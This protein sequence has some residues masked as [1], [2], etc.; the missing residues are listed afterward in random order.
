MLPV[1]AHHFPRGCRPPTRRQRFG[2]LDREIACPR[3]EEWR[4]VTE[5]LRDAAERLRRRDKENVLQSL[6]RA[7]DLW[8]QP[9]SAQLHVAETTLSATTG[10][11]AP[12]IRYGLPKTLAALDSDSIRGLLAAELQSNPGRTAIPPCLI[13]H[14]LSGNI[15][16]LGAVAIHLSLAIGSAAILKTAAGDPLSAALWARTIAEVDPELADC[17]AV[18]YWPGGDDLEYAVFEQVDVIVASGSDTAISAL[19]RRARRRFC[20][21]G[22]RVSFAAIGGE[23]LEDTATAATLA[24]KLAR[25]ISLWDQQ[26]CLSPQVCY[27]EDGSAVGPQTFAH[28]LAD[29]LAHDAAEFPP[30]RLNLDEQA[31]VLRF[32]QE[33]EWAPDTTLLASD[34]STAWS[35]AV[36]NGANF[37]P[38]CLNR[39]I[40]LQVVSHLE[41]IGP[42]LAEQRGVLEAAGV[43]VAPSRR[44]DLAQLLGAS[45]VHRLCP[46]GKLQEPPLTW[47]QG[48]RPRIADWVDWMGDE[49]GNV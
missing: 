4:T 24:R 37:R 34:H 8:A 10:F 19:S 1:R 31:A 30:R 32:R 17:L 47:C 12:M 38:T 5:A 28:M 2:D 6:Q 44:K 22:H 9:G 41:E 21:H 25:D 35:I 26:G 7:F 18:T 42:T 40:R 16:G 49:T 33:A 45:G 27:L 11:S 48:G 13:A 14:V 3:A 29:A 36:E 39:T 23:Y 15:P 43:A 20:G 46:V